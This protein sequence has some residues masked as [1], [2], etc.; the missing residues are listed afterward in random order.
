MEWNG[1]EWKGKGLA[2]NPEK[3]FSRLKKWRLVILEGSF[4]LW[5]SSRKEFS[6]EVFYWI[7]ERAFTLQGK[8][9][10]RDEGFPQSPWAY[11]KIFTSRRSCAC[12]AITVSVC[13]F[14]IMG[15]RRVRPLATT[16]ACPKKLICKSLCVCV[17]VCLCVCV[18]GPFSL[19]FCPELL[20]MKELS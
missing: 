12:R 13:T 6:L 2:Q 11:I 1:M 5:M 17:S 8:E 19:Q 4:P 10:C 7:S 15:W 14:F 9:T 16:S 3:Y 20:T 18:S